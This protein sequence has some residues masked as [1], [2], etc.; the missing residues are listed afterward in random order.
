M[1]QPTADDRNWYELPQSSAEA[2]GPWTFD[3]RALRAAA[4]VGLAVFGLLAL[5]AVIDLSRLRPD[6]PP[7]GAPT[8]LDIQDLL[9]DPSFQP[10]PIPGCPGG[11]RLAPDV[12]VVPDPAACGFR[13]LAPGERASGPFGTIIV[14][15]PDGALRFRLE[16]GRLDL[17]PDG[18]Q[19]PD[20][21]ELSLEPDGSYRFEADDG[22][23]FQL[24]PDDD[25]LGVGPPVLP[26]GRRPDTSPGILDEDSGA[27]DLD[28]LEDLLAVPDGT[29]PPSAIPGLDAPDL[30]PPE[31]EPP[32]DDT[33]PVWIVLLVMLAAVLIGLLA[34]WSIR[35]TE[36]GVPTTSETDADDDES[37]EAPLSFEYELSAL[38]RLL[39][40][41]ERQPR[42]RE[43]IVRVYAALETGLGRPEL[44][45]R[46]AE[47][48][49]LFV[50]RILGSFRELDVPVHDLTRLFE[51]ARFSDHEI[52]EDMRQQAM[53]SL[54]A[55]RQYYAARHAEP[56]APIAVGASIGDGT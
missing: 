45:R 20:D 47:T 25:R 1:Q 52:T 37:V 51:L 44:A 7:V 10:E 15:S 3:G 31:A 16:D 14:P 28:E 11:F 43:A 23:R 49:G 42:P 33:S 46:S 26:D 19:R 41:I 34:V 32:R 35:Q 8:Q 21:F 6:T 2:P 22:S 4:A 38:D 27:I 40:E 5:A 50:R 48:P 56:T 53:H 24:V 36:H 30:D 54:S 9:D 39:W 13:P 55:I 17:L 29:V 12:L 18:L